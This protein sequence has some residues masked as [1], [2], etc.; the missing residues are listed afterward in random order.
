MIN[1]DNIIKKW[2]ECYT[3]IKDVI[4]WQQLIKICQSRTYELEWIKWI[5][6][7]KIQNESVGELDNQVYAL[8]SVKHAVVGIARQ[9]DLNAETEKAKIQIYWYFQSLC[10]DL[11]VNSLK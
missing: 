6:N 9:L 11:F 8:G 3:K 7:L 10:F 1:N 2:L 4:I 5:A